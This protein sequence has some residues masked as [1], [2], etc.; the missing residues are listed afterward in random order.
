MARGGRILARALLLGALGLCL[1]P[2]PA[3]AQDEAG[4]D[5]SSGDTS[6]GGEWSSGE[7]GESS[8]GEA[9]RTEDSD[10][11]NTGSSDLHGD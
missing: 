8:G 2:A 6:S 10:V 4:G 1:A 3:L 9:D 11:W 7:G 5:D